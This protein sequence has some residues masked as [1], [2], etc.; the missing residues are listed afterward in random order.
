MIADSILNDL[1]Q[2]R[3]IFHTGD[4]IKEL[5]KEVDAAGSSEL[6]CDL[7]VSVALIDNNKKTVQFSGVR[8]DMM[9]CNGKKI[10]V[11]EGESPDNFDDLL[12]EKIDMEEGA[13]YYMFSNGFQNQKNQDGVKFSH[14]KFEEM[15]KSVQIKPLSEQ[16]KFINQ[17]L[18]D[19]V[20]NSGLTDDISVFGFKF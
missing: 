18:E 12:A 20:G 15:I 8:Q 3:K 2:D 14:E 10:T 13:T 5:K 17:N 7:Q 11:L 9:I 16:Y 6:Q 19:W 1:I 4:I